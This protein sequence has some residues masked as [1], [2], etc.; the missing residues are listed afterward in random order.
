MSGRRLLGMATG[1]YGS[2]WQKAR[3]DYLD[4]H[5]RCAT[6]GCLNIAT[7]VDHRIPHKGDAERFWNRRN[8]QPRCKPCHDR[9]T[10]SRD[11]G[12]GNPVK[13]GT[14]VHSG[15]DSNGRPLDPAHH[16]N[17]GSEPERRRDR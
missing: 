9:K 7:I 16:W 14:H 17:R 3:R 2:K 11:G 4:A 5:P 10:A 15:C 1:A 13:H 8:W 12:F 6:P